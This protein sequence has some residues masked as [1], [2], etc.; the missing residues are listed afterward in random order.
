MRQQ[1]C[2]NALMSRKTIFATEKRSCFHVT[3]HIEHITYASN[4]IISLSRFYNNLK[5]ALIQEFL[6][7]H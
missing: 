6:N 4:K 1:R 3:Y 5:K 7:K 2:Q